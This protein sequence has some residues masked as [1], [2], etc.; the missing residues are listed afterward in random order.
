MLSQVTNKFGMG[1]M[2][3]VIWTDCKKLSTKVTLLFEVK[4]FTPFV[5]FAMFA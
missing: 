2:A 1:F 4:S 3:W 5:Y